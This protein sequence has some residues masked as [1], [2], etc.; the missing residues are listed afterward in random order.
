MTIK[1]SHHSLEKIE[2]LKNHGVDVSKEFIESI[3]IFPD[4]IETVYKNRLI[5]QKKIDD[6]HVLRVVY[7]AETDNILIITVYPGRISRYE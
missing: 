6:T 4:K 7:E 2:I 3:I 1:F 5:A